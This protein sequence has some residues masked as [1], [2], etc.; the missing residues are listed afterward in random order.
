MECALLEYQ[1]ECEN[2]WNQY[3]LN[4]IS[5][6]LLEDS[7]N[8]ELSTAEQN[9]FK[10]FVGKIKTANNNLMDK[11]SKKK[12]DSAPTKSDQP[13][14]CKVDLK[15]FKR[16]VDK[17]TENIDKNVHRV[18]SGGEVKTSKKD[19]GQFVLN[20]HKTLI[21]AGATLGDLAE[22]ERSMS[23]MNNMF[24]NA[25]DSYSKVN[26]TNQRN[27]AQVAIKDGIRQGKLYGGI[28]ADAY[29]DLK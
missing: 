25:C 17:E 8:R 18:F 24:N 29:K 26:T 6:I 11:I 19:Y 5:D 13:K 14:T 23:K 21:N 2:A 27:N 12:N 1:I 7:S 15:L 28:L 20:N 3:K 4:S 9:K 22:A 16:E 10:S